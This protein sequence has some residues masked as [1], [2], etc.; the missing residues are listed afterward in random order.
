MKKLNPRIISIILFFIVSAI[1]GAT[2]VTQRIAGEHMGAFTYNGVRFLMGSIS[3]IP[4]ILLLERKKGD[5]PRTLGTVPA[6]NL[7]LTWI[8]GAIAGVV[9][10]IAA[11]LQQFGIVISDSPSSASEAGFITGMYII[12]VPIL[13]LFLKRK[14]RPIIWVSTLL[15]FTGLALI[16]L[17]GGISYI[18]LAHLLVLICAIFWAIH[19]LI[20]DGYVAR[21]RPITF[22]SVKFL[23]C[24]ILSMATALIFETITLEG[25]MGGAWVLLYGGI[26]ASGIAYTLQ[27]IG[28]KYVEPAL[29]AIIFSM[30]A[31]FAALSEVV[32]LGETMTPQKYLGGAII[33]TGIIL[34]QYKKKK[35]KLQS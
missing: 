12:F 11:N 22:V 31:L 28:Q 20:I 35:E 29:A 8:I 25:L 21:I 32:F 2:F 27:T 17:E 30:E 23:V 18:S 13:G 24:G 33:F 5:R 34:A 26:I 16:T 7:R 14:A 3:L 4:V 6:P 1:W 9:V 10:F 19:I 15:A